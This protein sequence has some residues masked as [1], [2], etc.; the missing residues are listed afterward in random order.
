MYLHSRWFQSKIRRFQGLLKLSYA[1]A[2]NVTPKGFLMFPDYYIWFEISLSYFKKWL[3]SKVNRTPFMRQ[4]RGQDLCIFFVR[5]LI[6]HK[7]VTFHSSLLHTSF[8]RKMY[9]PQRFC[10]VWKDTL[11]CKKRTK[12]NV[13]LHIYYK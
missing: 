13:T 3:F 2:E 1:N 4:W 9:T 7:L 6:Q 12:N 11:I 10:S 8:S 5:H